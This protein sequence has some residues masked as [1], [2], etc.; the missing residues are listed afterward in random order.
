MLYFY[1]F[2]FCFLFWCKLTLNLGLS[3]IQSV[4]ITAR[5]KGSVRVLFMQI[6]G[7]I[8]IFYFISSIKQAKHMEWKKQRWHDMKTRNLNTKSSIKNIFSSY[9]LTTVW[10]T[11]PRC[12]CTLIMLPRFFCTNFVRTL[13]PAMQLQRQLN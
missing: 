4:L 10:L 7:F 2:S 1:V 9:N 12:S 13:T 8:Y 5:R 3:H 11:T 6:L